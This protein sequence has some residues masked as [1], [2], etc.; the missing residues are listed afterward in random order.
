M[1]KFSD[2]VEAFRAFIDD[3]K[4]PCVGAKASLAKGQL[5]IV[6]ADDLRAAANDGDIL[7]SLHALAKIPSSA[8]SFLSLAVLFPHTPPLSEVA[9]EEVL[10][11]R[12][13][14]LHET[15]TNEFAWDENV[16]A[17][18]KSP[19]FGMSFGGCGFYVIG[20]HPAASRLA[21]RAPCAALVFNPHAQFEHLR[22]ET[23][24]V[25]IRDTVR[26]R[27]TVLQGGINPTMADHGTVSE[28]RQYSGR[29]VTGDWVCPFIA[30]DKNAA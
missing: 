13:Q 15:D 27:D 21:R 3:V 29:Q 22:R 30:V 23:T 16:S 17:D 2:L 9:F 12:L 28:A 1:S 18:P 19:Y 26:A 11:A 20:L 8:R 25:R 5:S 24:F 10:W 7:R 6:E 14:A 4:Y